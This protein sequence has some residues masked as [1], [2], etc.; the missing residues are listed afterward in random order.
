M[1]NLRRRRLEVG[2]DEDVAL[3]SGDEVRGEIAAA[4]VVE[5]VGDAKGRER[6]GPVGVVVSAGGSDDKC[7][8]E[9][10]EKAAHEVWVVDL[11]VQKTVKNRWEP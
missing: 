7:K 9:E 3:W 5:V 10:G 2:V 1:A 8:E 11:A 6:S 4:D